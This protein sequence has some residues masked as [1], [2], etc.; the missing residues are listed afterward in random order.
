MLPGRK[1]TPQD[2]ARI[3]WSRK[4]ILTLPLF[5]GLFLALLYSRRL[6]DVYESDTLIQ[7]VP[8]RIP[9]VYI[10]STVT[11][12]VEDRLKAM[13]QAIMSRT[14]LEQVVQ[15][16]DLYPSM[17]ARATMQDVIERMQGDVRV[18]MVGSNRE[19]EV[20]SFRITFS[21]GEPR[22]AQQVTARLGSLFIEENARDRNSLAEQTS[23]FLDSQLTEARG[24]L[25]TQEKKLEQ[26]REQHSGSLPTQLPSNLQASQNV[27]LQLTQITESMARDRDERQRLQRLF[28]EATAELDTLNRSIPVESRQAVDANGVPIGATPAQRLAALKERLATAELRLKPEHPD[29]RRMKRQIQELEAQVQADGGSTAP[30]SQT[31]PRALSTDELSRRERLREMRAQV[32][33]LDRQI[34]FKEGEE[35][36]L[37]AQV[38]QYQNRIDAVPGLESEWIRLSR[39]YETLQANY[40]DLLQKSE[41]SKMAAKM[42]L[43]QGGEQFRIIDAARA[44]D[45]PVSPDRLRIV[46]IGTIAG[47]FFGVAVVGLREFADTS[48]RS[49]PD[50]LNALALPVLVQIP[51]VATA[52]ERRKRQRGRTMMTAA[53]VA[54]LVVCGG[55]F[56]HLQLWKYAH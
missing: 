45:R 31:T 16:F 38:A 13:T 50:V 27:Q 23:A 51:F 44:S 48:Y 4:W 42:E 18:D 26:F 21:Y 24:R 43:R 49:E 54:V 52:V 53:A 28:T 30:S 36:R 40:R 1:Y 7:V 11:A 5:A 22:V 15:T 20:D 32:E 39:D 6:P 47:L 2:L 25:E 56:W 12:R 9:D 55:I 10:K 29:I 37:R 34:A 17:R 8:Q 46:L 35:R 14:R 3:L 33:S 41:N 19:R